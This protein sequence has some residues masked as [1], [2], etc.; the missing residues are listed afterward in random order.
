MRIGFK[1][2]L[3]VSI[4]VLLI[5]LQSF[6]VNA[7][8]EESVLPKSTPLIIKTSIADGE[9]ELTDELIRKLNICDTL[10]NGFY[11]LETRIDIS[12]LKIAKTQEDVDLLRECLTLV[13]DHPDL[14]IAKDSF[15]KN[16]VLLYSV[17]NSQY[18]TQIGINYLA[19]SVDTNGQQIFDR[20]LALSQ[21]A[22]YEE[23]LKEIADKVPK[24]ITD[25]EKLLFLYDYIALNFEYDTE[26]KEESHDAYHFLKNKMGVCDAYSKTFNKIIEGLGIPTAQAISDID[27]HAWTIVKIGEKYYH[28]DSTWADPTP[29]M[30]GLVNHSCFLKST[31]AFPTNQSGYGHREWYLKEKF[32]G[33]N[34][35]CE[36]NTYDNGY[37]WNDAVTPFGY[38]NGEYYYID[39][40]TAENQASET[41]KVSAVIRKTKDF[42]NTTDVLNIDTS[43]WFDTSNR[44][45]LQNY[46][47]GLYM[48]GS[49]IYY[50][51]SKNLMYY[52]VENG[53]SGTVF[54]VENSNI[55]DF[56]YLGNGDF[57]YNEFSV[58]NGKVV[59]TKKHYILSDMG[60][61]LNENE[62]SYSANLV[63]MRKYISDG[64]SENVCLLKADL[65]GYDG[66]VDV[67]DLVVLK[68]LAIS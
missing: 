62:A 68:K 13:T 20:E 66:K 34:V 24:D 64:Y 9:I 59:F 55:T 30:S 53:N 16:G 26:L 38:Y 43:I 48:V 44:Y 45:L 10:Y 18:Y 61:M 22:E 35:E 25:I 51:D 60:S 50:N 58:V 3:A 6:F 15:I 47:S 57:E 21:I 37:I 49:Q 12:E 11:G 40:L 5:L 63:S 32:L 65:S 4:T 52:D 14:F 56:N 31:S 23:L 36:D 33:L 7:L 39:D 2:L 54:T 29:D 67:R 17:S 28:I 19:N 27:T 1:R 8:A 42:V 41:G 46:N